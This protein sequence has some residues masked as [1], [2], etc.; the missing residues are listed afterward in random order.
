MKINFLSVLRTIKGEAIKSSEAKDAPDFTLQ[1]AAINA[2]LAPHPDA[3]DFAGSASAFKLA[4]RINN[5][6]SACEVKNEEVVQIKEA[7]GRMYGPIVC[8][9]VEMLLEG[10][11]LVKETE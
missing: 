3:K 6:A 11:A 4:L 2:L 9:P 8:G 1:D 5:E 7:I 10:G